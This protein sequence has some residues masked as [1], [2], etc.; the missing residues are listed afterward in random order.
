VLVVQGESDPFGMPP[1]APGR[2]VA[3][4]RG[5]HGL[6]SDVNALRDAVR[7]WLSDRTA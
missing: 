1:G 7:G 2:V 4:I 6:K 3:A 5:N